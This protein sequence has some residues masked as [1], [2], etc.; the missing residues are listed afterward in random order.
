[1]RLAAFIAR[2]S[3]SILAGWQSFATTLVPASTTM[4]AVALLGHAPQVLA[5]ISRDPGGFQDPA[6]PQ[7]KS[8]GPVQ[9]DQHAPVTASEIHA[10]M[11]G[12]CAVTLS[13]I[14]AEHGALRASMLRMWARP[15][16]ELET[17]LEDMIRF[18]ESIDQSLAA[19]IARFFDVATGESRRPVAVVVSTNDATIGKIFECR[20]ASWDHG[21]SK[22]LPVV[23]DQRRIEASLR[24][25]DGQKDLFIA[26][27]AH[28]LRNPLGPIKNAVQ[29]MSSGNANSATIAWCCGVIDRQLGH[30]VRLIDDL[31][32]SA[33]MSNDKVKLHLELVSLATVIDNAIEI[34]RP[35]IDAAG[36]HLSV[37]LPVAPVM[38]RGDPM[39][40][41][42]VFANLLL[43][44]AKYSP[45][46]RRIDVD[47][48]RDGAE[49][50]VCIRDRG[51]GI[52]AANLTTVFDVYSQVES[53]LNRSQGGLGIGLSLVKGLVEM[54]GGEVSVSSAGLG[55]GSEF[56]VC[57]PIAPCRN[58]ISSQ[59]AKRSGTRPLN[60]LG[61]HDIGSSAPLVSRMQR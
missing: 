20:I 59:P 45:R 51:I 25:T 40:L 15:S 6:M 27:L 11:Q 39:R 5:A 60:S 7:P 17:P 12:S 35:A 34:A 22:I 23:S 36:H 57:L 42:Q 21:A 3:D 4:N 44:A 49:V 1:M 29:L 48:H 33:R 47:A 43:N 46:S 13:Q 9:L 58:G 41:G 28:E 32:D 16:L 10:A 53:A 54:H 24:D 37:S 61:M 38:L 55:H 52:E 26:T 30:L 56:R 18:N 19:S 14:I 50:V 31:L 8:P 2:K